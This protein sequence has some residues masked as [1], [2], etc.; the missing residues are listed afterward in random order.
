[1]LFDTYQNGIRLDESNISTSDYDGLNG[2]WGTDF[3]INKKSTLGFLIGAQSNT[4]NS[5]SN[6]ITY[7]SNQARPIR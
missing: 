1:M 5:V 6:N 4:S 3:F 2:R 7:I